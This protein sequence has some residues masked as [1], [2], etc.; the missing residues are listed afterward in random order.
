M[1]AR[2]VIASDWWDVAPP[3]DLRPLDLQ[4]AEGVPGVDCLH[5]NDHTIF[6]DA[7][8]RWQLWACVRLAKCGRL[9]ARWEADELT[10]SPWRFTGEIIRAD[11]SAGE[12]RI[13]WRGEEFIQSPFGVFHAGDWYLFFGGYA[14]GHDPRGEP[15]ADYNRMEN[16]LC[17]L[18]SP[19]GRTWTRH[20]D[21]E[22]RSRVFAGPGAV[23][24]PWIGWLDG[25]W[26]C[27]Y[28][29]H[30]DEDRT[31]AGIYVRTSADLITWSDWRIAQYD[32]RLDHRGRPII[33]ES[34]FVVARDG[35]YYL[36]R[37]HG[38]T[39]GTHVYAS[40]DPF[41]FGQD[42]AEVDGDLITTLPDVIAPEVISTPQGDYL[43]NVR[44]PDGWRIRM[45]RLVWED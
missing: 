42:A 39:P 35:W 18:T 26:F 6:R 41:C 7:E 22:G 5:P 8:G 37:T 2:P 44:A 20:R 27:Y 31:K 16:Q 34:P 30:H 45:A 36:F 43:T 19:D 32:P 4:P 15:T 33:A 3:P 1:P 40:R 28:A 13:D 10:P 17:L 14:S 21:A 29:G 38:T 25:R 23:R 12:S 9:L 11:R 24:D